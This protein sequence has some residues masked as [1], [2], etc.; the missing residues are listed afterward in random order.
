VS[1][2]ER[3]VF[4]TLKIICDAKWLIKD[5]N[6]Y[7]G[8]L[9]EIEIFGMIDEYYISSYGIHVRHLVLIVAY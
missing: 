9:N 7:I 6:E 2:S 5:I 4:D 8:V 3:R 1:E